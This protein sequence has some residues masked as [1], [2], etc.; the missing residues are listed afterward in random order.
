MEKCPKCGEKVNIAKAKFQSCPHCGAT[1][2]K[3]RQNVK[4]RNITD[5]GRPI[6]V[7]DTESIE[8]QDVLH[9]KELEKIPRE[10]RYEPENLR[11]MMKN[12]DSIFYIPDN[13]VVYEDESGMTISHQDV[14]T[15]IP[16]KKAK[17]KQTKDFIPQSAITENDEKKPKG[18]ITIEK[19][20]EEGET[21]IEEMPPLED[22]FKGKKEKRLRPTF[23]EIINKKSLTVKEKTDLL[24]KHAYKESAIEKWLEKISEE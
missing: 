10:E 12:P 24:R 20:S 15:V 23:K 7:I 16:E 4:M 18:N 8:E 13:A 1:F 6:I 14:F 3:V 11:K 17:R 5:D 9:E 21:I 2:K 19:V 22:I